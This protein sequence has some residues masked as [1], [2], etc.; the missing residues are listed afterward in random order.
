MRLNSVSLCDAEADVLWL[1]EGAL[2]PDEHSVVIEAI[3]A[4]QSDTSLPYFEFGM[5][6]GR[7]AVFLAVRAPKG[8]L[9]GVAMILA[10]MKAVPDGVVERIVTP[11][12]RTILQKIAVFLRTK[13]ATA[14]E[15]NGAAG[16]AP[17]APAAGGASLGANLVDEILTLELMSEPAPAK[18]AAAAKGASAPPA[19]AKASAVPPVAAAAKAPPAASPPPKAEVPVAKAAPAPAAKNKAAPLPAKSAPAGRAAPSKPSTPPAIAGQVMPPAA[20]DELEFDIGDVPTARPATEEETTAE[21][22]AVSEEFVLSIADTGM[23]QVIPASAA[24]PKGK[25]PATKAEAAKAPVAKAAE[26]PVVKAPVVEP[27]VA[28]PAAASEAASPKVATAHIDTPVAKSAAPAPAAKAAPEAASA[29]AAAP[30]AAPAAKAP[31][32]ES[33]ARPAASPAAKLAAPSE[34][35]AAK[36]SHAAPAKVVTESKAAAKPAPEPAEEVALIEDAGHTVIAPPGVMAGKVAAAFKS[37][38]DASDAGNDLVLHVQELIKLRSNGRTRRYEVLA[39][40]RSDASRDEVPAHFIAESA[41]G[42]EGSVLD[43]YVVQRLLTW[44]GEH[45]ETVWDTEPASFSINLSIGAIEDPQFAASVEAAL[46][47]SAVPTEHIGFE[48]TE[49][50]CVQCKPQVQSFLEMVERLGCFLVIDNFT[51]DTRVLQMLGSS[52]LRAVKVDPKLTHIAMKDKLSQAIVVA[53]AQAC[54]VMGVHCVA[55]RID[56]QAALQWL[57][58]VGCDFAQGYALEKPLPIETLLPG[59]KKRK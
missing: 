55:K 49:F 29:K 51:F 59:Q 47:A 39:R 32:E 7:L 5:E 17:S 11:Q 43:G 10:E 20:M 57:T 15:A 50:A 1:S 8:D 34:A 3:G 30:A 48:I 22:P 16:A 40:S 38:A 46:E 42:Q 27:P 9:V 58:A 31:V 19:P 21:V 35:P 14:P 6:D 41:Q 2:G 33:P 26:P 53:I 37:Q 25:A 28:K 24:Q 54:K 13:P 45:G 4:L 44:L 23:M 52:A 18:P 56:S 12:V 36:T